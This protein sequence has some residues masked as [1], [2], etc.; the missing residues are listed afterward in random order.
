MINKFKL[1]VVVQ[2]ESDS[3]VK[4]PPK[5]VSAKAQIRENRKHL[6]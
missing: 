4:V 2:E 3:E 6:L 1:P 5:I